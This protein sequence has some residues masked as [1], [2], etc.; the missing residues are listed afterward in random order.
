MSKLFVDNQNLSVIELINLALISTHENEHN[1]LVNNKDVNVRRSLA[2][3]INISEEIANKLIL[4]P[5]LNVSFVASKNPNCTLKREFKT[6]LLTK[7]V[8]CN[9]DENSINCIN[10]L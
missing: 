10:C 1:L 6:T 9:L 4:D 2:K 5:V 7:C 8:L 3:N